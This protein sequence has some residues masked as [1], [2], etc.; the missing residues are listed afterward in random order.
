[1]TNTDIHPTVATTNDEGS[2]AMSA[3]QNEN[4]G[5]SSASLADITPSNA[6]ESI[7]ADQVEVADVAG[8]PADDQ[9]KGEAVVGM[10]TAN[11]VDG[12]SDEEIE[13][14]V[15]GQLSYMD[16]ATECEA[17]AS[18]VYE[19]ET[20]V[21]SGEKEV[22]RRIYA[23]LALAY[24]FYLA[25]FG[26]ADYDHYL[27]SR[28][29]DPDPK[30]A[31]KF[32]PLIKAVFG[33]G[34]KG[35]IKASDKLKVRMR[36]RIS[37]MAST[38]EFIENEATPD[39]NGNIDVVWFLEN[40][41]DAHGRKGI[42]ASRAGM[43][44]IRRERAAS[45]SD[46]SKYDRGLEKLKASASV[47]PPAIGPS[48]V[49]LAVH[50]ENGKLVFLGE[51]TGDS[52]GKLLTKFIENSG[53]EDDPLS[54][55][56]M[57]EL[58]GYLSFARALGAVDYLTRIEV[59]EAGVLVQAAMRLRNAAVGTSMPATIT[60]SS[61]APKAACHAQSWCRRW[62]YSWTLSAPVATEK[63]PLSR[64]VVP[65]RFRRHTGLTSVCETTTFRLA[66]PALS[67]A[68]G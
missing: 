2:I 53:N 4:I 22:W 45:S 26:T 35:V 49:L 19:A 28:G 15:P 36:K 48:P 1:M 8:I 40:K 21:A 65:A 64:N 12:M 62:K 16:K 27:K 24:A 30:K 25:Y 31:C 55:T 17:A 47:E 37:T 66:L 43:A 59:T 6:A 20:R 41:A 42:E 51:V 63:P 68:W 18:A 46:T 50:A 33:L 32:N 3:D 52:A 9:D 44:K 38:L 67:K 56:A 5:P 14:A 54:G 13:A 60:L 57:G 23:A 29:V 11:N 39:A 61:R 7:P 10:T 34:K 58:V